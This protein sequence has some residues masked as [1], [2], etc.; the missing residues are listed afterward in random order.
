M[1]EPMTT[2]EL[3]ALRELE[4]AATPG[5]WSQGPDC[6]ER[7]D[8]DLDLDYRGYVE[9]EDYTI[10]RPGTANPSAYADAELIAAVRNAL[11]R[12]LATVD[13]LT[14]QSNQRLVDF[15]DTM[16]LLHQANEIIMRHKG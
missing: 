15:K 14:K 16:A 12:L 5:P 9:T 10:V 4:K 8:P 1:S 11:P 6:T 2:E 3:D 13:H 7:G